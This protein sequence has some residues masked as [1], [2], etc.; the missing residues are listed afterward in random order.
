MSDYT[1]YAERISQRYG[2]IKR[3]GEADVPLEEGYVPLY[4]RRGPAYVVRELPRVQ[5]AL[6]AARGRAQ[7]EHIRAV[8]AERPYL[9]MLLDMPL[10]AG[11]PIP[12]LLKQASRVVL[13][14]KPGAG[15]ST[16]LRYLA[17]H[18]VAGK[19]GDLL[20]LIVDLPAYGA[21]GQTLP[22]FLAADAAEMAL[23]VG[24]AF[25]DRVLVHGQAVACL[26][27]LDEIGDPEMQ[28]RVVERI[29]E[30]T[31]TYPRARFLV[32]AREEA[33]EPRLSGDEFALY[34]L[35]PWSDDVV[36]ELETAWDQ[37]S[38][39][40]TEE[41]AAEQLA[42][43][44]RIVQDIVQARE[45][46][47]LFEDGKLNAGWKEL[48]PHL[49]D[50]DWRERIALVYRALSREQPETWGAALQL[51]LEAGEGDSFEALT[52]RHLL[53]A[54][55]A[56]AASDLS[57]EL[58]REVV[59]TVVGRLFDW[60]TDAGAA[61]RQEAF[62]VLYR[63]A[64]LHQVT[65]RALSL[66][67]DMELGVWV[68]E[69]AAL[70]LGRT[71]KADARQVVEALDERIR[72]QPVVD[73]EEEAE[74]AE[75]D[76]AEEEALAEDTEGEAGKENGQEEEQPEKEETP[77][78]HV[79]V[80]QAACTSLGQLVLD[81][82]LGEELRSEVEERLVAGVRDGELPID[83]RQ[84]MA[85]AL[86]MIAVDEPTGERADRLFA[87]ARGEGEE[88]V[89]YA[90]QL[91]A[92]QGLGTLLRKTEDDA[93]VDRLWALAED[94]EAEEAVRVAV[95]EALG[96]A[97]DAQRAAHILLDVGR[98]TSIYPPGRRQALEALGRVGY[99]DDAIV[100]ALVTV[101]ETQDRKTKDFE[102][103][104]AARALG[105]IGYLDL[106]L[107]HVLMLIADKSIYRSTRN[108][109]LRLLGE[110][111]LSGDEDLDDASIAVLRIWVTED[112]TTEDVQEQAMESL[113]MLQTAREEVVRDLIS[114]VQDKRAYPRVRRAAVRALARLP[115]EDRQM[116]VDSI[117]VPFYDR[118]ETSDLLRVPTARVLYLW[119]NDEHAFEYLQL[120]AEQSYMAL[121]RYQ[122]GIVL[123]E[124]GDDEHAVPTLLK[125]ATDPSIA[126]PIRCD[127]M[128]AL[129][130]WKVGDRELAEQFRSIFEEE[131]PMPNIPETAYEALK[132][133][134]AA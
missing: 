103:L 73:E 9:D 93:L 94:A 112:R 114:V 91:A 22:E 116:V 80:R 60:L 49:W 23:E 67:S 105:E 128:R 129:S 109:A 81:P 70:L 51:L 41:D 86:A 118:E 10:D 131:E 76:V 74:L 53:L 3:V 21:S 119:G 96:A 65:E 133:L 113:V 88:R 48:R 63:F 107:Q 20:T 26:D 1:D 16:A 38:A 57:A 54:G 11:T 30:W 108:D 90:V 40:W 117:E 61:G 42:Q 56:L 72:P 84:A 82:E 13:L 121:V 100:E 29:E 92:A 24:P 14:G 31:K 97:R 39:E 5:E 102:R 17:A 19:D 15:K 46:A 110:I 104:A 32:T 44:P 25:F 68:R 62:E 122:A 27:G 124:I 45:L 6:R 125:L 71:S 79:R 50:A 134:L 98:D 120:A 35:V 66:V 83:V 89:P 99:A 115:I 2:S 77:E 52:H 36:A 47:A 75:E 8:L 58:D 33:Y 28:A 12:D 126:D 59:D 95:A 78:E 111:G 18:P 106:S 85:E 55:L 132:L 4:A 87:L 34:R 130:L 101:S 127:S 37:A 43:A 64:D 123:H 69:A 7:Q